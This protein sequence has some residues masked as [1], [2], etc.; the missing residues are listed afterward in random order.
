MNERL[1]RLLIGISLASMGLLVVLAQTLP[2]S[3]IL[4]RGV[5]PAL[6]FE[7]ADLASVALLAAFSEPIDWSHP[8]AIYRLGYPGTSLLIAD[9]LPLISL[10]MRIISEA[11]V[12]FDP[13]V[14]IGVAVR[15]L[16]A[17][18]PLTLYL[19]ARSL[20]ASRA[21][22]VTASLIGIFTPALMYWNTTLTLGL[23]AWPLLA[24]LLRELILGDREPSRSALPAAFLAGALWWCYPYLGAIG[25]ALVGGA[26]LR[27][28]R[29][30]GRRAL[31]PLVGSLLG[32]GLLLAFDLPL[33]DELSIAPAPQLLS[34]LPSLLSFAPVSPLN[35]GVSG[36]EAQ[37]GLL[38]FLLAAG[39]SLAFTARHQLLAVAIA[40]LALLSFGEL[41]NGG[42]LP[43]A[44]YD[45]PLLALVDDIDRLFAPA[46]L[47]AIALGPALVEAR[48]RRLRPA[49]AGGAQILMIGA[50]VA[51]SFGYIAAPV[52]PLVSLE[53]TWLSLP[54]RGEDERAI[55][56][57]RTL[58]GAHTSLVFLP[59]PFCGQAE[60][61]TDAR[62]GVSLRRATTGLA[63][64][65]SI[66]GV[67]SPSFQPGR[68]IFDRR[69]GR[70]IDG[71]PLCRFEFSPAP[72]LALVVFPALV[73][74]GSTSHR[75]RLVGERLARCS[76]R[77][78]IGVIDS[79]IFCSDQADEIARF[80][81]S[82]LPPDRP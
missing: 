53:R 66:E 44:V 65:A 56:P 42:L 69:F 10:P 79:L 43:R 70:A 67:G 74:D 50:A 77:I 38:V 40:A 15:G 11:G 54:D 73:D 71:S 8:L 26:S 32:L 30:G 1:T 18:S 16:V 31:A 78:E 36:P 80:E 33:P 76:G 5:S 51:G 12:M 20:G 34:A 2:I 49:L 29:S 24:L 37:W 55:E 62:L 68:P 17:L 46:A 57:L 23:A 35:S 22:A 47:V 6:L 9:G 45:L 60:L 4:I 7:R 52:D 61:E 13:L 75:W 63:G 3:E 82:L 58:I 14:V 81:A 27:A 21:S 39:S 64:L 19:L 48:L 25:I 41:G 59:M 72:P 28:R